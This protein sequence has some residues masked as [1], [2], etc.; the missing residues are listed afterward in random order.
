MRGTLYDYPVFQGVVSG[1][2]K[3]RKKKKTFAGHVDL[4]PFFG[5]HPA[6]ISDYFRWNDNDI[7]LKLTSDRLLT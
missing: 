1:T 5:A 3:K 2:K 4:A 6:V 7:T